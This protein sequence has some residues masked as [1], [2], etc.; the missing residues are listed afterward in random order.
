MPKSRK[1]QKPDSYVNII[2]SKGAQPEEQFDIYN[3][4]DL[5]NINIKFISSMP[6]ES[7][8]Y[9]LGKENKEIMAQ[10]SVLLVSFSNLLWMIN[11]L[12]ATAY[13]ALRPPRTV[14]E[15]QKGATK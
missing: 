2:L 11:V 5:F 1:G 6:D 12:R 7:H 15:Q 9:D 13:R 8:Q 4:L 10:Q 14:E 3:Y